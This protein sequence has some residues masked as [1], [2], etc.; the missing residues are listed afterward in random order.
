M[1][2]VALILALILLNKPILNI[3]CLL[4]LQSRIG[5]NN[6]TVRDMEV[7]DRIRTTSLANGGFTSVPESLL[8]DSTPC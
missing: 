6:P 8:R 3:L 4:N 5:H 2:W 7:V 1:S